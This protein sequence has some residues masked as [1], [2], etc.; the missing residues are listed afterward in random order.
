VPPP[1]H[2]HDREDAIRKLL[3]DGLGRS[4]EQIYTGIEYGK[5]QTYKTLQAMVRRKEISW[6]NVR[7]P[8][9]RQAKMYE[10]VR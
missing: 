2:G 4:L 7:T 6:R 8:H 9:G 1:N 5:T 10:I 3:D